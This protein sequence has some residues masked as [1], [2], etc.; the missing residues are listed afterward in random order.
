M[1]AKAKP[2]T[3]SPSGWLLGV[4]AWSYDV[5]MW[6]LTVISV[7]HRNSW[8]RSKAS[9]CWPNL[10][11]TIETR[12]KVAIYR[13]V[14]EDTDKSVLD[15]KISQI[16]LN[17]Y[18]CRYKAASTTLWFP[19]C[20]HSHRPSDPLSNKGLVIL[21][22]IVYVGLHGY[23]SISAAAQGYENHWGHVEACHFAF[24]IDLHLASSMIS[25]SVEDKWEN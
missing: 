14:L 4:S 24:Q 1:E 21:D 25:S 9:W 3:A 23:H 11:Q 2:C 5:H 12:L 7:S 19:M 13:S 15:Q 18:L 8:S 17:V 22:S 20:F 6:L 16:H 10:K